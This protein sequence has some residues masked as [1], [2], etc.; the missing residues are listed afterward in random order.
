MPNQ[1]T[2]QAPS[3]DKQH[4]INALN[5]AESLPSKTFSRRTL[6]KYSGLAFI[7]IYLPACTDNNVQNIKVLSQED[8]F[9]QF[10]Q[11]VFPTKE[12]NLE[13]YLSPA[14]KRIQNLK[15]NEAIAVATLYTRFKQHLK[16]VSYFGLKE[17]TPEMGVDCLADVLQSRHENQSNHALDII[18]SE[19]SKIK[20]LT[21]SIWGRAYSL[22]DKKCVYWDN[23][24]QP[25]S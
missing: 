5:Q 7:G 17:Y 8:Q 11:L 20:G 1:I 4:I 15:N 24:D 12:L 2:T 9:Q 6:L 10:F 21:E 16:L 25:V 13:P 18:Y 22:T 23:Y 14:I 3:D 19:I